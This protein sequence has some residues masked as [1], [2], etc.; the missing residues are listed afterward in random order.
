MFVGGYSIKVR[1]YDCGLLNFQF[2]SQGFM[3]NRILGCVYFWIVNF[4]F[5]LGLYR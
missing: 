5:G 1:G 4:V 2:F 3:G